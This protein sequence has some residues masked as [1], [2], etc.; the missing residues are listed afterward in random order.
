MVYC[1]LMNN[2]ST[3]ED[4]L[5]TRSSLTFSAY[6]SESASDLIIHSPTDIGVMRN[7][8]KRGARFSPQTLTNLFSKMIA[9]KGARTWNQEIVSHQDQELEC[10][11][12]AQAQSVEMIKAVL[13]GHRQCS[14][15]IHLGGGHD[16]IYPLV[17]AISQQEN[18]KSNQEE[19]IIVNI[20]AHLDSRVDKHPHSGTPFRQLDEELGERLHLY[21]IGIHSYANAGANYQGMAN[22]LV[23]PTKELKNPADWL[24]EVLAEHT[25]ARL[26]LS[27]DCDG[28]DQSFMPAV[29]APNHNGLSSREMGEIMKVCQSFWKSSQQMATFGLYEYNPVFDSVSVTSGR[30]LASL[31]YQFLYP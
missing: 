31:I 19:L 23:A 2:K 26:I 21:Q 27:L 25:N 24:I 6:Q 4:S 20:D 1:C 30:Y 22:M 18:Q 11:T 9:P 17:K 14:H 5:K 12:S 15:L 7:A 16:H 3:W 28:L 8:G 10:F 29:S 13:D